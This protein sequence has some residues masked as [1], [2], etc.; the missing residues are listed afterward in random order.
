MTGVTHCDG[1][2]LHMVL[3][4]LTEKKTGLYIFQCSCL[5]I[6]TKRNTLNN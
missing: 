2:K 4:S 3:S 1:F 6:Q 5:A